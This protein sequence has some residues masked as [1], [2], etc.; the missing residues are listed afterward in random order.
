MRF[1][2]TILAVL[3]LSTSAFAKDIITIG[4]EDVADAVVQEFAN[5]GIEDKIELQFF[6]GKT[7][8]VI[9]NANDAKIL[10]SG[11]QLDAEQGRFEAGAEI[12]VDGNKYE[13]T[14]LVGRYFTLIEIWAPANDIAKDSI[15]KES[16]LTTTL[17]KS[18][19]LRQDDIITKDE[20]I[21]KQ[22]VHQLKKN[23]PVPAKSIRDEVLVKKGA[24][25]SV[26]YQNKGMQITAKMEALEDASKSQ[27][28]KMLNT[29][30]QKE[31]IGKVIGK[32]IV[33]I[34]AE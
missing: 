8:F 25:V 11:L 31:I 20:L 28:V 9:E 33:E 22:V 2:G 34:T 18:S 15:I 23:K 17:L 19:R 14:K 27:M 16:D 10:I 21:G 26:I 32:N 12:F 29:K 24:T 7:A 5:Q 3:V 4:L 30:S 13:E 1:W 6:G